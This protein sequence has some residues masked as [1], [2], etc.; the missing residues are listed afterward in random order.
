MVK[1]TRH[2]FFYLTLLSLLSYGQNVELF[3]QFNGHYDYIAFGN[4]LNQEENGGT[5]DCNILSESSADF[6]LQPGQDLIAAFLY[7]A[8]SGIGDLNVTLNGTSIAAERSFSENLNSNT[9][10]AAFADITNL[11]ASTGNGIYTLSDLVPDL[12]ASYCD[13]P[14]GNNTNFAGWA[15]TV[16]FEDTSLPL[17]QVNVFDGLESVS[18]TNTNLTILLDNLNVLDTT[19]AKIGFV[20]WEGDA[21]LAVNETLQINGNIISNPPLNPANNQFNS[22]NSFTGSAELYNMDI[23]VYSI[24]NYIQPGDT[25]ASID[26]T[27]GQDFVMINNVIT[28]LNTEL[29]DATIEII[30]VIGGTECGDREFEIDYKILNLNSTSELPANTPIAFYAE[31]MLIGQSVTQNAI[32]IGNYENGTISLLIPMEIQADFQLNIVVDDD[33]TGSGIV[34]EIDENNNEDSIN[35]H[36]LIIPDVRGIIGLELCDVIGTEYFDLTIATAQVNPSYFISYHES[37]EDAINNDNPILNPEA[38]ENISNPQVIY[39][40]VSNIDCFIVDHFNIEVIACPLPDATITID[41]DLA[42][43]RLKDLV[44]P[45]SVHNLTATG[46]I[47]A[48][49][50]IAFYADNLLVAQSSTLFEIPIGGIESSEISITL[51]D[52]ILDIFI[53]KAVVDDDGNGNGIVE[54]LDELNNEFLIEVAFGSISPIGVVPDLF[55]CD[56]GGNKANFDLTLQNEIISS[57]PNDI[58]R[59]FTSIDSA[60]ANQ[61]AIDDPENYQNSIDPQR[62]YVRLDN[63]ICFTIGDFLIGTENCAPWVPD[64]FS[65][66]NDGINDLFEITGLLNVFE[67]FEILIYSREGNLIHKGFNNDG[68]WDGVATQGILHNGNLVPVGTYYYV[69]HLNDE[70]FPKALLGYI[71]INY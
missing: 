43:C 50:P 45:F 30:N 18:S 27:S 17:N 34:Q 36:L 24:E 64:G 15:V 12:S 16:I 37:E 59:Y 2:L 49:T 31:D 42:A 58:I 55:A 38:Y 9:Y 39:V 69:L 6:L 57:G 23:D 20:A 51:P 10:F 21:S 48:F 61:N 68:F 22:T 19:G 28:V 1:Y 11:V 25:T 70:K 5:N 33:G 65:P 71:Y 29:P 53:L 67:N 46:P 26:L 40:R 56:E 32:P 3:Q 13:P 60:M 41:V 14:L 35:L 66:N 62:I 7:W 54:E 44:V 8:G 63:E 47:P 4:T 52:D